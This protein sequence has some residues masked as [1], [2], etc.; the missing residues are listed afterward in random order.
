MAKFERLEVISK[1][2]SS[3][4][5]PIFCHEKL[6]VSQHIIDACVSGGAQVIEFTNREDGAWRLFAELLVYCRAQHSDV[7]LGIGTVFD[8]PTAALFINLGADFVVGPTYNSEIAE[9][10]NRRKTT[11]I[12]G[13]GTLTEISY[14]EAGGAELVKIFPGNVLGPDFVKAVKAPQPWT[15]MIVTG[16]VLPTKAGI[17]EWFEAGATAVG[18]GSKL[19][20]D[21][22]V[23][24]E[25]YD[26]MVTMI[27]QLL[28]WIGEAK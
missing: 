24:N 1:I 21:E 9:M 14:A 28:E 16:G 25:Q 13:C 5:I 18:I 23:T 10:C 26:E 12:P 27:S 20:R 2:I 11:Y 22:W 15:K 17:H 19:I 6:S 7:A 3:G 8:A 4:L